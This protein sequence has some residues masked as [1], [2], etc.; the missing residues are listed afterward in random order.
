MIVLG[1]TGSIGMGKSTTAKL[2]NELGIAVFDA[3]RRVHELYRYEAL[4]SLKKRFPQ[5][6][7]GHQIDRKLLG[8]LVVGDQKAMADL[9]QIVHPYIEAARCEFVTAQRN[10]RSRIV[11]LDIPLLLETRAW[12]EVD[13]IAVVSAPHW[14]QRNRVLARPGMDD[15][16]FTGLLKRQ[17]PDAEKRYRAHF[18]VQSGFGFVSA[19]RQVQSIIRALSQIER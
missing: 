18:T 8:K 3:D 7:V 12:R 15:E 9:E 19:K 13:A 6:E 11:V 1:L 5:A 17:M 4:E 16:K 2:F 14:L 10:H